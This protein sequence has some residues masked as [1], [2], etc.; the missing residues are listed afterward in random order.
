MLHGLQLIKNKQVWNILLSFPSIT[1]TV[2]LFQTIS[3]WTLEWLH[4][5]PHKHKNRIPSALPDF[6]VKNPILAPCKATIWVDFS[7][8]KL[9]SKRQKWIVWSVFSSTLLSDPLSSASS[10]PGSLWSRFHNSYAAVQSLLT[11][12][13]YSTLCQAFLSVCLW[14]QEPW[15]LP[16]IHLLEALVYILVCGY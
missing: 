13:T 7:L 9:D 12:L 2:V 5:S 10:V 11:V 8:T 6:L 3:A 14:R 16:D 1:F 4:C 15:I